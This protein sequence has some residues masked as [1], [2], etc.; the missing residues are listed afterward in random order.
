M[1]I[2]GSILGGLLSGGG[3]DDLGCD[4]HCD[5]CGTIMNSQLGFSVSSGAWTCTECSYVNDVTSDNIR[6]YGERPA[7]E[8]QLRYIRE[9]EALLDVSFYGN[10]LE[11]ASDFIDA[12][13]DRYQA[14][15]HTPHKYR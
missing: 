12:H 9:I 4:W 8:A 1:S 11:E 6:H 3:S 15:L 13:K 14:K 10:T 5:G 2:L 7:T